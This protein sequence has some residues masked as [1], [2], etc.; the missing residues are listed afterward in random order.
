M[1]GKDVL[2]ALPKIPKTMEE[3]EALSDIEKLQLTAI[4][5]KKK[6]DLDN[7]ILGKFVPYPKQV[8]FFD[9]TKEVVIFIAGNRA[10]KTASGMVFNIKFALGRLPGQKHQ[11]PVTIWVVSPDFTNHVEGVLIPAFHKWC[12]P[13]VLKEFRKSPPHAIFKNGSKMFFKSS[14]SGDSKFMGAQVD[15]LHIDE[16]IEK[17][18]VE[19]SLMR[20][21][22]TNGLVRITLT[23]IKGMEWVKDMVKDPDNYVIR[24]SVYDNPHINQEA[25]RKK[26]ANL[27]DH[28]RKTREQGDFAALT[29]QIYPETLSPVY[30][31]KPQD[32]KLDRDA[33]IVMC[34]DPGYQTTAC[35]WAALYPNDSII[36]MHEYYVHAKFPIEIAKDIHE[37]EK[38]FADRIT[39]RLIDPASK[40][41]TTNPNSTFEQYR[42]LGLSFDFAQ[43]DV[44]AGI[45]EVKNYMHL[46]QDGHPRVKF[47]DTLVNLREEFSQYIW[48]EPGKSD[49]VAPRKK[50]DHL[51][52]CLRYILFSQPEYETQEDLRHSWV[53]KQL[54]KPSDFKI[55]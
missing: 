27:P 47:Y 23:P 28:I 1:K 41:H 37:I 15:L 36:I 4:L 12:P 34:L 48:E 11:P 29:G 10:G 53:R 26:M 51:M 7:D 46:D 31:V 25:A 30:W 52:D 20:L 5:Q 49:R 35:L 18:V 42:E 16:E 17:S 8:P 33:N 22:D 6:A 54:R 19:E 50:H 3:F 44:R 14:D 45:D 32:Y 40:G 2:M 38:N 21:I 24:S 13:G 9:V 55:I 43:N 39:D